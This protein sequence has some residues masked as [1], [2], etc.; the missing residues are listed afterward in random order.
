MAIKPITRILEEHKEP[1][2]GLD[3]VLSCWDGYMNTK[4]VSVM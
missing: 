1:Q 2:L 4:L 3:V